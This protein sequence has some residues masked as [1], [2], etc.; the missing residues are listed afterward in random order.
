MILTLKINAGY[1]PRA[2]SAHE[3]RTLGTAL[4]SMGEAI[5]AAGKNASSMSMTVGPFIV[6]IGVL[7][8]TVRIPG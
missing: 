2:C 3:I 7:R 5:Q 4:T 1:E 8:D 6:E